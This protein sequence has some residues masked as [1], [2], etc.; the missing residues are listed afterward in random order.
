MAHNAQTRAS[1]QDI[2][3]RLEAERSRLEQVRAGVTSD[4][5]EEMAGSEEELS[6][7]DQHPA[8]SGTELENRTETLALLQQ[9]TADLDEVAEAFTRLEQG[10]YGMCT[11][12]GEPVD[13]ERLDALPAVRACLRDQQQLE[14]GIAPPTSLRT[15]S[16]R[17]I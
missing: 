17:P 13:D 15:S 10:I 4:L 8:D 1:D 12:C 7:I 6:S 16:P 5:D 2:R 11:V 9:V 3:R 14:H